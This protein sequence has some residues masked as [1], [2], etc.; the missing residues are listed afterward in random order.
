METDR[1]A[2]N[3]SPNI[4]QNERRVIDER[5][6]QV[7]RCREQGDLTQRIGPQHSGGFQP[8]TRWSEQW[9]VEPLWE[10]D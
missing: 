10:M 4:L 8:Q 7:I 1:K 2:Q 5:V 9:T 3:L 6:Q